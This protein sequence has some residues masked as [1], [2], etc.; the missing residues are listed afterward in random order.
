MVC[1]VASWTFVPV[2]IEGQA[3]YW[4]NKQLLSPINCE[5]QNLPHQLWTNSLVDQ[6]G[7][8]VIVERF[9]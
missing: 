2:H 4:P 7:R 3:Y 8:S 9:S 6:P 5:L 1:R